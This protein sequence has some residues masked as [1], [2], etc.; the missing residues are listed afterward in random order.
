MNQIPLGVECG[1]R[2]FMRE[3]KGSDSFDEW[4]RWFRY[5]TLRFV[6]QPKGFLTRH[7]IDKE[8]PAFI[9]AQG[10]IVNSQLIRLNARLRM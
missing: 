3:M 1:L 4:F 10:A 6:T 7:L 8:V 9:H 5:T 2:A